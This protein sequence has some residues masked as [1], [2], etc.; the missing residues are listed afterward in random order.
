M[1]MLVIR[2]L[3]LTPA[4][5]GPN[6]SDVIDT[7]AENKNPELSPIKPVPACKT[8]SLP[9]EASKKKAIGVGT[10]ATASH[11]V[12]AKYTLLHL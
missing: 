6:S 4:L 9:D 10:N 5:F 12:L 7:A 1:G 3:W 8:A 2:M 11:P